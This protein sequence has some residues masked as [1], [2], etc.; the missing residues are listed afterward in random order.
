MEQTHSCESV[1]N[2]RHRETWGCVYDVL[3]IIFTVRP[4]VDT[5]FE[6]LLRVPAGEYSY[7]Q[8]WC[9]GDPQTGTSLLQT[10]GNARV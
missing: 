8:P 5:G 6:W 3:A 1:I 4:H 10:K 7:H 9:C 2:H